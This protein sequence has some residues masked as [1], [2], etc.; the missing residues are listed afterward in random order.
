MERT[1]VHELTAAYA[2]DALDAEDEREYEEHLAHCPECREELAALQEAA[3]ALAY[4]TDSPPPPPALRER[5]LEQ[6]RSERSNVVPLRPRRYLLAATTAAAAV[7]AAVAVGVGLWA[8]SLSDSLDEQEQIVA[9]LGDQSAREI[10]VTGGTGELV[11]TD[12]GDAVLSVAGLDR[13]P[14][15]KTY[16]TWVIEG[17]AP[18]P[19]G[20]FEP[21]EESDAVTL[22]GRRVQPGATVAVTLEKDGGVDAPTTEPL[23]VAR[24]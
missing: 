15:G 17:A 13:P 19:A 14:E 1:G 11:V 3:V 23:L 5:I 9:I 2:L 4:A 16:E 8:A 18:L 10:P 7:A 22:L 20:L 21:D 6:A 12:D 24:A